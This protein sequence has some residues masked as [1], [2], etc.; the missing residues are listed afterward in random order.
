MKTRYIFFLL[1]I[2][3]L[4][5]AGCSLERRCQRRLAFLQSNCPDC[6]TTARIH[7]TIVREGWV[8]DTTFVLT[9]DTTTGKDT[10]KADTTNRDS[11]TIQKQNTTVQIDRDGDSLR[12]RIEVKND[13]LY[14]DKPVPVPKPVPVEKIPQ[15]AVATAP[16]A[17]LLLFSLGF[18][19]SRRIHGRR[20]T[21]N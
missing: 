13:T 1:I 8:H 15:W 16:V 2:S 6:F 5:F 12:V 10:T 19:I 7:D 21:K 11:F 17:G 18:W 4:L 20:E 9:R 14:L 3:S